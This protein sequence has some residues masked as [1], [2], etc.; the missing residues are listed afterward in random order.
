MR[1][2]IYFI[3]SI[4]NKC[5][6]RIPI[7]SV[8]LV[9]LF[10]LGIISFTICYF[11]FYQEASFNEYIDILAKIT[12]VFSI[13]FV[14]FQVVLFVDDNREKN[15][16]SKKEYSAEMAT[17]YAKELLPE[18]SFIRNVF[19]RYYTEEEYATL[20]RIKPK[21]FNE[22]EGR[23]LLSGK[24]FEPFKH[25]CNV[26]NYDVFV[27]LCSMSNMYR[28]EKCNCVESDKRK[29]A[30]NDEFRMVLTKSVNQLEAFS[31]VLVEGLAEERIL[32]PILHQTFLEHVKLI[33][34]FISMKNTSVADKYFPNIIV[35]YRR[36]EQRNEEEEDRIDHSLKKKK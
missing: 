36:W 24:Y 2:V 3:K 34:P 33:Y 15:K 10:A 25:N 11:K 13:I 32:Y 29:K 14:V 35:L 16:R 23:Q 18:M 12:S 9:I 27:A 21:F 28:P 5:V 22:K 8:F 19:F 26:I 7:I 17:K 31:L 20:L 30:Y 6:K 4:A 1:K